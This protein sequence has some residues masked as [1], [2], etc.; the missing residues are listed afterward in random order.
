VSVSG[1][2]SDA[3]VDDV[4]FE[5]EDVFEDVRARRGGLDR[6]EGTVQV[7]RFG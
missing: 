1:P 4:E 3:C 5:G 2:V 7:R 6:R